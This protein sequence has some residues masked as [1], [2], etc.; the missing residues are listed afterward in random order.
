MGEC[1]CAECTGQDQKLEHVFRITWVNNLHAFC[2]RIMAERFDINIDIEV[3]CM[4]GGV[5]KFH[6]YEFENGAWKFCMHEEECQNA[7]VQ[8]KTEIESIELH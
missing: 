1:D 3:F 7:L 4:V 5:V 6:C 2:L 8:I